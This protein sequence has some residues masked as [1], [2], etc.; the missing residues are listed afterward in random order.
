MGVRLE[1]T[2]VSLGVDCI[3]TLDSSNIDPDSLELEK[4][5]PIIIGS[6]P[7]TTTY[8][9]F[10]K[11]LL[12]TVFRMNEFGNEV[13]VLG[14]GLGALC[15]AEVLG[16]TITR[17]RTVIHG[18]QVKVFHEREMILKKMPQP[19]MAGCYYSFIINRESLPNEVEIVG[20]DLEGEIMAFAHTKLPLYGVTFEPGSYLTESPENLFEMFIELCEK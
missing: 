7:G 14:I 10:T 2:L 17:P 12:D 20:W 19:F 13:P 6:G 1:R 15:L 8:A 4:S 9:G 18:E 3:Q 16:A 5:P 11:V